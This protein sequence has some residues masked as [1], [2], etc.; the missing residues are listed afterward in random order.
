MRFKTYC[1]VLFFVL[2]T[3]SI[4]SCNSKILRSNWTHVESNH[5]VL[6]NTYLELNDDKSFKL[7]SSNAILEHEI[8]MQH[9][10]EIEGKYKIKNRKL[11]LNTDKRREIIIQYEKE[12]IVYQKGKVVP[13]RSGYFCPDLSKLDWETYTSNKELI[14]RLDE[15]G[16]KTYL[17][18]ED[19][20]LTNF[21]DAGDL[22]VVEGAIKNVY[23][24]REDCRKL[25]KDLGY[26]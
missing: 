17:I 13:Y 9:N 3:S 23:I 1:R 20:C 12:K 18:G 24:Q 4:S 26:D 15:V 16:R 10:Y 2:F 19:Y 5:R 6:S 11:F 22:L 25:W 14:F 8:P 7:I 21:Y